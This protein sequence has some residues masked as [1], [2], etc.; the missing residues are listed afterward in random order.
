MHK[1]GGCLRKGEFFAISAMNVDDNDTYSPGAVVN[2]QRSDGSV[3]SAKILGLSERGADYW[4]I[5]YERMS[6]WGL[7]NVFANEKW[8][9]ARDV[10]SQTMC[11]KYCITSDNSRWFRTEPKKI[12]RDVPEANCLPQG[13]EP[14][15]K[16]A[17]QVAAKP[18]AKPAG[19]P[20]SCGP[21]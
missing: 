6:V 16:P 18:A 9:F 19:D 3:V 11:L 12:T 2:F 7:A 4:S 21:C 5:T 13:L 15:A 8:Y 10:L 14:P 20:I 17:A 1:G